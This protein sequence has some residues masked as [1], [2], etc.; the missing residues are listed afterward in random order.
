MTGPR[1][2]ALTDC[3]RP[4]HPARDI[5]V[6]HTWTLERDL[7]EV[8]DLAEELDVTRY[9]LSVVAAYS[10][11]SSSSAGTPLP[12]D[13]RAAEIALSLH[14]AVDHWAAQL[15][16]ADPA[17]LR[18]MHTAGVARWLLHYLE[19]L[20]AHPHAA[21]A[22]DQIGKAV[23]TGWRTVDRPADRV[24]AGACTPPCTEQLYGRPGQP[25][26][27]CHTCGVRHDADLRRSAMQDDLDGRLMT[28]AEIAR[29]AQY[30]GHADRERARNLL[31]V[32]AARGVITPRGHTPTGAP[33]YPFGDT[34]RLLTSRAYTH[35][36]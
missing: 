23:A 30:F 36:G 17:R 29:L 16:R 11:T 5:C 14:Q 34:L 6:H 12:F 1:L 22:V 13:P 19:E 8:P 3:G 35:T 18:P 31:K 21:R 10:G 27:T 32:W 28:G 26:I 33:L 20:A 9:R 24:Y 25:Y 15:E 7:A 4:A 2:C